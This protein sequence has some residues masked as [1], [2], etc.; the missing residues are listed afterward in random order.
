MFPWG[1][2]FDPYRWP[3]WSAKF[4]RLFFQLFILML[5]MMLWSYFISYA[6][7]E[8]PD[9]TLENH[10]WLNVSLE[11]L[12]QTPLEKFLCEIRWRLGV[13]CEDRPWRNFWILACRCSKRENHTRM[14]T[15]SFVNQP[16]LEAIFHRE[17]IWAATCD[18]QQCG[19]LTWIDSDE[20]V[21][22]PIKLRNSKWCS[23]SSLIFIEY[24]SG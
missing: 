20:H 10:K 24:S 15:R 18:F 6:D 17:Y 21:L 16:V 3:K 22:P 1:T 5:L 23:V 7:Q 14:D 9:P 2:K 4:S 19:I 8:G 13:R 11:I 12:E